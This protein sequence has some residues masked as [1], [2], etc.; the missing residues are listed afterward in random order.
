MEALLQATGARF[1]SILMAFKKHRGDFLPYPSIA[2]R[3]APPS[4]GATGTIFSLVG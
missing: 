2:N 1:R 3:G 4:D